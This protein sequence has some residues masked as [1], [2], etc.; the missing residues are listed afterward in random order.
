MHQE[1][2]NLLCLIIANSQLLMGTVVVDMA[3]TPL[4]RSAFLPQQLGLS[5]QWGCLHEEV[6]LVDRDTLRARKREVIQ[7]YSGPCQV[8]IAYDL[9]V[10]HRYSLS[11]SVLE[12][13]T[14]D[15]MLLIIRQ[16]SVNREPWLVDD[17]AVEVGQIVERYLSKVLR[18]ILGPQIL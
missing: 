13:Y 18:N 16:V 2:N 6:I 7:R 8:K 14:K 5:D 15:V 1:Y 10:I 4:F 12:Q 9:G 11:Q 3:E 17:L